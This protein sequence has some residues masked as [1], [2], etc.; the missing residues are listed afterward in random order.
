MR[1]QQTILTSKCFCCL[2]QPL[3]GH[4]PLGPGWP[5]A[6]G[7]FAVALSGPSGSALPTLRASM[8][9]PHKFSQVLWASF[10]VMLV[11]SRQL[12]RFSTCTVEGLSH[13][14]NHQFVF[15]SP[16]LLHM[17]MA[18]TSMLPSQARQQLPMSGT[19]VCSC[20]IVSMPA[21]CYDCDMQAAG[22]PCSSFMGW[23]A[24]WATSTLGRQP[25]S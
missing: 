15:E 4:T 2:L 21:A 8:K 17:L 20:I 24:Q 5:E 11:S 6:A 14:V 18:G 23:L 1:R 10:G 25:R 7:I 19:D 13:S 12:L 16:Y 3:P 9:Q 22:A